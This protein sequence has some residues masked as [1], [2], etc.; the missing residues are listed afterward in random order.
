MKPDFT[1]Y[2]TRVDMKCSDGVT[3][4]K[5]AF[6][7]AHGTT[8]PLVWNHQHDDITNVL[9]HADLIYQENGDVKV[10]GYYNETENGQYAKTAMKHGDLKYLSIFANHVRKVG[11]DVVHGEIKEVSLVLAGANPGAYIEYD[12]IAHSEDSDE[13]SATIFNIT[14]EICHS[15]IPEKEEETIVHSD[16]KTVKDVVNSMNDK[17]KGVLFALIAKNEGKELPDSESDNSNNDSSKETFKDILDSM[18]DEQRAV[19]YGLVGPVPQDKKNAND[20]NNKGDNSMAHNV[21]EGNVTETEEGILTHAEQL[22]IIRDM[23]TAGSLRESC[24]RHDATEI[25]YGIENIDYLFPDNKAVSNVP[26]LKDR[27]QG[28]VAKVMNGVHHTPFSRIKSLYADITGDK[29]RALGYKK[30]KMKKEEVIAAY[31]RTTDPT[32]IYKKQK[33]DRDDILDITD[34]DV[35]AWLKSEM[36]GKLDE[37]IARA[38]LVGDGRAADSDDHIDATKLRPIW[39]DNE[40]YVVNRVLTLAEDADAADMAKAFIKDIIRARKDYRGSGEPTLFCGEDILTE[41]LLL[42]DGLGHDM[43]DSVEKLATKLR[44]KE[45]VSVPVMD[46]L[47]RE[48]SGEGR[49]LLGIVVNLNDYNVGADK[50]GSVNMF[51][52]FDIDYNQEKYL[53]ETRISGALTIPDSAIVIEIPAELEDD[54]D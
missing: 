22:E 29:A 38:I 36:R 21:F 42:E 26:Y 45:I 15:D 39:T 51:E 50:G 14:E 23:K 28:W 53:I 1:G 41:C 27:K 20:N 40:V 49:E 25:T 46:G 37:E 34:F 54:D 44:V 18:T 48:V 33:L 31:K 4:K 32:T 6:E 24:L 43:Y 9:G 30:G 7:N 35:V 19:V 12:S 8:V 11:Q 17:Q 16:K 10:E 5:G 47:K 13:C 52:D 3:I 2:A